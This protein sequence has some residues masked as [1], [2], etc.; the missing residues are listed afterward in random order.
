MVKPVR[1][2]LPG[3]RRVLLSKNADPNRPW[4]PRE[5]NGVYM[6]VR[7]KR[8]DSSRVESYCA[9]RLTPL[10]LSKD[11]AESLTQALNA[12]RGA[13]AVRAAG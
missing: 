6:V 7:A 9:D 11:D 1:I 2:C 4:E 13:K 3:G 5:E 10:V 8:G 12:N